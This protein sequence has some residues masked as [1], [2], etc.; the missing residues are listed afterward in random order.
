MKKLLFTTII[1]V[2]ALSFALSG[3]TPAAATEAAPTTEQAAPA[4]QQAAPTEVP[5]TT[6]PT[7]VPPTAEPTTPTGGE[8]TFAES[9]DTNTLDVQK[10]YGTPL[11]TMM[12]GAT[13]TIVDPTTLQVVPY[14]AESWDISPD[15]LTYTFHL[16]QDVKFSNGDPLTA[17]DWVYTIDRAKSPE[18]ASPFSGSI[19][20]PIDTYQAL[21]DY[22]LELVLKKPSF[23]FLFNLP[24]TGVAQPVSKRA[25]EE[26][27]GAYDITPPS[28]GP[29]I[30]DEYVTG[31]KVV[32]VSNPDYNWAPAFLQNG[33]PNIQKITFRILPE[34]ATRI[35]GVEAGELDYSD[36][37]LEDYDRFA[38]DPNFELTN[39]VI[40]GMF[41]YVA[42]N[43]SKPPFD[44]LKVRQAFCYAI[45]HDALVTI[46][47]NGHGTALYSPLAVG[48]IGYEPAQEEWGYHYDLEKAKALMQE[49][50]YTYGSDGMLVTPDGKPF[51][52]DFSITPD[53][54]KLTQVLVEQYKDL[55]VTLNIVQEDFGIYNERLKAGDY[56]IAINGLSWGDAEVLD[57]ALA[58][59]GLYNISHTN[60]P[61]LDEILHRI[62]AG[63]DPIQRQND[64]NTAI[65]HIDDNALVTSLY[66]DVLYHVISARIKNYIWDPVGYQLWL[67]NAYIEEP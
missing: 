27:G 8:L 3:C 15:G 43:V 12:F 10:I 66:N 38:Q 51:I 28:T 63:V 23:T 60:D 47:S 25:I 49:A 9:W 34:Y 11:Y 4:E 30:V 2:M 6:A 50:G 20:D 52:L 7:E 32:L 35:A 44:N 61:V 14:L 18:I 31:E 26:M 55:G 46:M 65:Q 39:F 1:I 57:F 41:P 45:N 56:T 58:S 21:D 22:T 17:Q 37:N 42:F 48:T 53:S 33:P 59:D 67:N 40:T 5:P 62:V 16:R 24:Q 13:L 64:I 19:F 54:A 36:L 29:Y